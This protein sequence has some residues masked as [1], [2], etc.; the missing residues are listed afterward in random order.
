MMTMTLLSLSPFSMLQRS[1]TATAG[2]STQT[3][4]CPHQT[5]WRAP[6]TRIKPG[7]TTHNAR[8]TSQW[9][10]RW[11]GYACTAPLNCYP[12]P[13]HPL[14]YF[15]IVFSVVFNFLRLYGQFATF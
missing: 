8:P 13:Q 14:S 5:P 6:H 4:A 2:S 11:Y 15:E 3:G 9:T 10:Y 7:S 1:N 12:H